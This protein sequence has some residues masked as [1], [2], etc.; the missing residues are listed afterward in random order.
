VAAFRWSSTEVMPTGPI[1]GQWTVAFAK[2]DPGDRQVWLGSIDD[3]A[4]AI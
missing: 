2:G 3:E 1:W 4:A